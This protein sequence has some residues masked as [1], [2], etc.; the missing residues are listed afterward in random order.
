M[1]AMRCPFCGEFA[2]QAVVGSRPAEGG[3]AI[4]RRRE[5]GVCG[6]RYSTRERVESKS[7]DKGGQNIPE[8]RRPIALPFSAIADEGSDDVVQAHA[9]LLRLIAPQLQSEG[10][11][12]LLERAAAIMLSQRAV[13]MT[14]RRQA[15]AWGDL[16][17]LQ[18]L[19]AERGTLATRKRVTTQPPEPTWSE[20]LQ[21][22]IERKP[23]RPKHAPNPEE[24]GIVG[25][26]AGAA[27]GVS[28]EY[29][30]PP[31]VARHFTT[32]GVYELSKERRRRQ[33][34]RKAS[35]EDKDTDGE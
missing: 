30:L 11:R 22:S 24:R 10:L 18:R 13:I 12:L 16:A 26:I 28:V 6:R 8:K 35:G 23:Q 20:A 25:E 19:M 3:R 1:S 29:V 34:K 21:E 33:R 31:G 7:L 2:E 5:C 14:D 9:K 15:S 27:H 17:H 4:R 32:E